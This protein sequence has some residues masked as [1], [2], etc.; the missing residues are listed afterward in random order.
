MRSEKS[1]FWVERKIKCNN[2]ALFTLYSDCV[3]ESTVC[4]SWLVGVD[5][6]LT[7]EYSLLS[8]LWLWISSLSQ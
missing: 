5:K 2:V 7:F 3:C 1:E 6:I 8:V 4:I